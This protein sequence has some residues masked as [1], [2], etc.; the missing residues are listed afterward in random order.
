MSILLNDNL[1]LAA[2]KPL[3]SRYGP[4][5]TTSLATEAIKDYQR[6]KGLTVGIYEGGVEGGKIVEYWFKEG[7]NNEQLVLKTSGGA[8]EGATGATGSKG[9]NGATGA[10]GEK[11][12][13]GD[14][15]FDG[16]TGATGATGEFGATGATGEKG[17]KGD[18]GNDG[19]TGATGDKG[20][21]GATGASGVSDR[22]QTLDTTTVL[23]PG[24]GFK[25]F[26][27]EPG[28]SYSPNQDVKITVSNSISDFMTGF[29][30]S[31]DRLTGSLIVDVKG[32]TG[33]AGATGGF[34]INLDGAVGAVG[35]TGPAG[36][37]G[38]TGADGREI[39]LGATGDMLRWKYVGASD[40]TN[41]VA[42]DNLGGGAS[43]LV[44]TNTS[45][46]VRTLTGYRDTDTGI[47]SVVRTAQFLSN[48]LVLTLATF[49]PSFTVPAQ[50]LNWDTPLTQFTVN[51]INPP[52]ITDKFVDEV[53]MLAPLGGSSISALNTFTAGAK[54][55]TPAGGVSW[56][57]VFTAD[58]DSYIRSSTSDTTGGKAD[59]RL[60]FNYKDGATTAP[61]GSQK[62]FTVSWKNAEHAITLGSLTGKTFLKS[63]TSVDYTCS[64][65]NLSSA[66][67]AKHTLT[68][69]GGTLPVVHQSQFNANLSGV[70]ETFTFST[71]ITHKDYTGRSLSLSTTFTRPAGVTGTAYTTSPT[72]VSKNVVTDITTTFYYPSFVLITPNS[73]SKPNDSHIVDSGT[74]T[75]FKSSVTVLASAT[76]SLTLKNYKNTSGGAQYFW[77]CVPKSLVFNSQ[78]STYTHPTL[79]AGS[80]SFQSTLSLDNGGFF[81]ENITV[82]GSL[83]TINNKFTADYVAY[84][85]TISMGADLYISAS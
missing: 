9:E 33:S 66:S 24:T 62:D 3:D 38:A 54:T 43:N 69:T 81:F 57:Q 70:S 39:V 1:K 47:E 17:E 64:I 5:L 28:L 67:N 16:A 27:V 19:A 35:A 21:D 8:G 14:Y 72:P 68:A 37:T 13:K 61:W 84:G 20:I 31:Y 34:I 18:F 75:G 76:K 30:S 49:E 2:N 73:V 55:P 56:T 32:A 77:F 79:K 36:A 12:D 60:S 42:L 58:A 23:A 65:S 48:K 78:N 26:Q 50:N 59:G 44:F 7:V 22:Y 83:D 25:T 80:A 52:D 11:G 15:G 63:Y 82:G 40:W 6:Y 74:P 71:P 51:V 45:D 85:I 41:L 29:V 53:S 4:Y 10:T 46:S